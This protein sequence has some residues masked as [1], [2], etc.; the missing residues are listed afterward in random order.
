MAEKQKKIWITVLIVICMLPVL[1]FPS[2]LSLTHAD[3]PARS[4]AWFYPIYV[5]ASGVCARICWPDRKEI[6]WI[7]LIMMILS[8]IG[9]WFLVLNPA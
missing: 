3:T 5:I 9:M 4:L 2:M 6:T 1:T 8:H 7:L